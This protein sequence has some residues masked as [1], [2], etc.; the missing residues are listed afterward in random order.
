MAAGSSKQ[1]TWKLRPNNFKAIALEHEAAL[2][3]AARKEAEE[4][5]FWEACPASECGPWPEEGGGGVD[6]HYRFMLTAGQTK[7]LQYALTL[8]G[9]AAGQLLGKW[10][11]PVGS[12][13]GTAISDFSGA[14]LEGLN[15]CLKAYYNAGSP[16]TYRCGIALEWLE[17]PAPPYILPVSAEFE[18]CFYDPKKK[19][20]YDCYTS[21]SIGWKNLF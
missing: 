12:A 16:S 14:A 6:P 18:D 17:A 20:K 9:T 21:Y 13:I 15:Y 8:G 1:P 10:L 19:S 2:E 4:K 3:A 7:A 11:G 5:A